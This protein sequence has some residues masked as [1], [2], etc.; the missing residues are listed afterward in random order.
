MEACLI[1]TYRCN[2]R[3][4]KCNTWKYPT[5]REREFTPDLI[6]RLPDNLSFLNLTG[7]EPF[8]RNDLNQIIEIALQKA[9]RLVISTNGSHTGRI[10]D[11][12]GKYGNR[13]GIR[14]SIDGLPATNDRLRG[15]ENGFERALRTLLALRDMGMRDIGI[16]VTVSERNVQDVM[17]LY[18]MA[19]AMGWEFATAAPHNSFYFHKHDNTFEDP[20]MIAREL[21]RIATMLLKS[22]RPKNWFRAYFNVGL[23]NRVR[24]RKRPLPCE[25][26]EDVFFLDPYGDVIPCN[27]SDEP[28]IMG[29][30]IEQTF[31]EIWNGEKAAE[32][33]KKIR[34]C[35]KQC[36]MIGSVSAAMKKRPFIPG[37][38]VLKNKLKMF[39]K[40]GNVSLDPVGGKGDHQYKIL[41]YEEKP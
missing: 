16:G 3:C 15:I 19:C 7:G 34:N 12:A 20:E 1:V 4:Y 37:K 41:F 5:N 38:W 22:S 11:T 36:W 2:A 14:I 35:S 39:A 6:E 32:V 26:G 25:V 23:A 10:L 21:E 30:L 27:G 31:E 9:K 18:Q 40:N 24:G 8:I 33:R 28:M 13:V 17:A 29:N